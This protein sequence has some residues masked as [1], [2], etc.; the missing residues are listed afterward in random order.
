MKAE[1]EEVYFIKMMKVEETGEE[2]EEEAAQ[3][4]QSEMDGAR[5]R[6]RRMGEVT[7]EPWTEDYGLSM[8]KVRRRRMV[9]VTLEPW[10][11]DYGLSMDKHEEEKSEMNK[12]GEFNASSREETENK[13][14]ETH[15]KRTKEQMRRSCAGT[16]QLQSCSVTIQWSWHPPNYTRRRH[17]HPLGLVRLEHLA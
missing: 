13:A 2:V 17:A 15:R 14:W 3:A 6:R 1:E 12:I 11:E 8:D 5:V 16:M 7:L 4:S 9:E 10:T